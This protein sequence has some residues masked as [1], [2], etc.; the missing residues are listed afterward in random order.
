MPVCGAY[1]MAR[2]IGDMQ[3]LYLRMKSLWGRVGERGGGGGWA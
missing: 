3:W 1:A 2:C